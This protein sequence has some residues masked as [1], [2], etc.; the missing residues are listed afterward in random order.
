MKLNLNHKFIKK[1]ENENGTPISVETDENGRISLGD[2][3]N[4][5]TLN[6]HA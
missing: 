5:I 6:A 1:I 2:L 3:N 4:V